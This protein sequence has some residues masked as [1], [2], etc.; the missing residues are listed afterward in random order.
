[1]Q[2]VC[3]VH[4]PAQLC[5]VAPILCPVHRE[6]AGGRWCMEL[7]SWCVWDGHVGWVVMAALSSGSERL[8]VQV[9]SES[10]RLNRR[11]GARAMS[12]RC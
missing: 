1:M 4:S 12:R 10:P 9:L 5:T 11:V 6:Q 2:D 7:G 8:F 3:S